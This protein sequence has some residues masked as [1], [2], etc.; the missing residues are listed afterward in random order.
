MERNYEMLAQAIIVLA[1]KDYRAAALKL[2]KH[3]RDCDAEYTRTECLKFFRGGLFS[4][5]TELDP[6]LLID[7]LDME[8]G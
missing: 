6:E 3:P 7:K 2:K 5:L 1:T 8:V 4:E